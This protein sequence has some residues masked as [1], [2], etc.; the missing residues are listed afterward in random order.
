MSLIVALFWSLV[1]SIWQGL[2]LHAG[3]WLVTARVRSAPQRYVLLCAAQLGLLAGFVA[4]LLRELGAAP[5]G[6]A[7][8][9]RGA[10]AAAWFPGLVLASVSVWGLGLTL[11]T[12]RLA[13]AFHGVSR[14]RRSASPLLAW[15][16]AVERAA[17]RLG[18]RRPVTLGEA[19]VDS[20]LTLG[21]LKPV[22]LLPIGWAAQLPPHVVE[23][24]LLHE[25][26]HVK[27][28]D[29]LINIAQHVVETLFFFHPSVWWISRQVRAQR[30][31]SCDQAVVDSHLDPLEYA[32]ALLAME[33]QRAQSPLTP[34]SRLSLAAVRGE[35]GLRVQHVL[36]RR[37]PSPAAPRRGLGA[38]FMALSLAAA[39]GLGACLGGTD[40]PPAS[41]DVAVA[42]LESPSVGPRWLP[43]SV[44]RFGDA[45]ETAAA[46]HG[47]DPALVS[48][49]VL[50][51]SRG[52]PSVVSPGGAVGLM[53]LM[54]TT[55]A[56]I[57]TERGLSAPTP[58]QLLEPAYNLD[59]GAYLLGQLLS[60]GA[61]A[62]STE[63][64][65][66]AAIGYNGG[67]RL[68]R[69]YLA[70]HGLLYPET[71]HY[72]TLLSQLWAERDADSSAT[73]QA[74]VGR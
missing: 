60:S 63:Q 41:E 65:R 42:A 11:M 17:A 37:E 6:L 13:C 57:A 27:R 62:P 8:A 52:N 39:A 51:E 74:L 7:V 33:V 47:V 54:P 25:L 3:A 32:S 44:G 38:A 20:P 61:G 31:L 21:W 73:Y 48:L 55:A 45:I 5:A 22:L 16:P 18:I 4:T 43:E 28:H 50:V 71:E 56:R 64:V 40:E 69:E 23:A 12:A 72:S 46:A 9:A 66:L 2:A 67:D 36:S 26:V 70:G 53:Q 30:E 59:F 68:L 35:L 58:A 1:H 49:V 10:P 14:L 24:A 34:G 29:Y 19:A 15:Q